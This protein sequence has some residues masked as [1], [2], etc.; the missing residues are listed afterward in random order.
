MRQ[1]KVPRITTTMETRSSRNSQLRA[2][3]VVTALTATAY[4]L[5]PDGFPPLPGQRWNPHQV[6]VEGF[7][8]GVTR[9]QIEAQLGPGSDTSDKRGWIWT[10]PRPRAKPGG[11]LLLITFEMLT[12]EKWEQRWY[13]SGSQFEYGGQA[14]VTQFRCAN[15]IWQGTVQHHFGPGLFRSNGNEVALDYRNAEENGIELSFSINTDDEFGPNSFRAVTGTTISWPVLDEA[16]AEA[17]V[18][19][20][21][22]RH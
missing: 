12:L 17:T 5:F 11:G 3:L 13:L 4:C 2:F 22:N 6:T 19:A 10:P 1:A 20:K 18:R 9:A 15:S 16:P 14:F 8:A 7:R 21:P